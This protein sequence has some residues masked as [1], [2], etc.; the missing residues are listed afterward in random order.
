MDRVL[1]LCAFWDVEEK[2][3]EEKESCTMVQQSDSFLNCYGDPQILLLLIALD[4][5][6]VTF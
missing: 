5:F 1:F 6:N 2:E 4:N 3:D